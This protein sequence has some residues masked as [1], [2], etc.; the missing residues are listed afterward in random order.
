MK[1]IISD[2]SIQ[3]HIIKSMLYLVCTNKSMLYLSGHNSLDGVNGS[4]TQDT[5]MTHP[6]IA[7]V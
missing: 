4:G 5:Y 3:L 2:D 1:L 7:P 6:A